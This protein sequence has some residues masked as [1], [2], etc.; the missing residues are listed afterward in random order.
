MKRPRTKR[1]P[2]PKS[3]TG[4]SA[5]PVKRHVVATEHMVATDHMV[6][7]Q[8]CGSSTVTFLPA[9]ELVD[10]ARSSSSAPIEQPKK[11]GVGPNDVAE[12][13]AVLKSF[14]ELRETKPAAAKQRLEIEG[15]TVRVDGKIIR[16]DMTKE[17]AEDALAFLRQLLAEPGNWQSSPD[18]GKATHREGV[19]FDL[20]RKKLPD[21]IKWIIE[22]KTR[23]GFRLRPVR[24]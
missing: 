17:T 3:S 5:Q 4:N 12:P 15:N 9:G 20:L 19:R 21:E 22:S 16:L 8:P 13:K 18:I 7:S 6:V 14:R 10:T 11:W 2:A 1:K 24:K 23:K